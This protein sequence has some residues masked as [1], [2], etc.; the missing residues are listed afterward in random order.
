MKKLDIKGLIAAPFTPMLSDGSL[1]LEKVKKYANKL[2]NEGVNGVFVC[3]TTGEGI[4]MNS[5]ERKSVVNEWIKFKSEN[6]KIIVHV[7]NSSYS[8]SVRLAKHSQEMGADAIATMGPGFLSPTDVHSLIDYCEPIACAAPEL[9]FYYYHMPS[10]SHVEVPMKKF[11]EEA[12]LRIPNLAGIKFSHNNLMEFQQCIELNNGRFEILHGSD[13]ILLAGLSLG[14]VG[15]V[16]STFN[17]MPSCYHE[18]ISHFESRNFQ[19]ARILQQYSVKVVEILKKYG[20]AVRAGKAIMD[21]IGIDCGPCRA[22]IKKITNKEKENL[23][24]DLKCIGFFENI[25]SKKK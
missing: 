12:Q 15:A 25:F 20:G 3:G 18:I 5:H 22:P 16:G 7:G 24:N 8:S 1:N 10:V 14:A 2:K 11:L 13:E 9:P 17:Y 4:L 19:E 23:K 6:F 21:L